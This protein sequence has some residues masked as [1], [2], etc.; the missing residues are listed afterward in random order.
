MS[1]EAI[2]AWVERAVA[3]APPLTPQ[4]RGQIARLLL[5][6]GART[7]SEPAPAAPAGSAGEVPAPARGPG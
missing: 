7:S 4:R 6:A 2:R 3:D 5:D 1:E